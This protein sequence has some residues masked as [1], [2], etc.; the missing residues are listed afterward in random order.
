MTEPGEIISDLKTG[1]EMME[2]PKTPVTSSLCPAPSPLEDD[3][4]MPS[5]AI[6]PKS[7][8]A[9]QPNLVPPGQRSIRTGNP[10][11]SPMFGQNTDLATSSTRNT[12]H[13][14]GRLSPLLPSG[15]GSSA[16]VGSTG[17]TIKADP[18]GFSIGQNADRVRSSAGRFKP[19]KVRVSVHDAD[20]LNPSGQSP[21][22]LGSHQYSVTSP[23]VDEL[24]P[25][26]GVD[27]VLDPDADISINI[28]NSTAKQVVNFPGGPEPS[29]TD[30]EATDRSLDLPVPNAYSRRGAHISTKSEFP[31]IPIPDESSANSRDTSTLNG[32]LNDSLTHSE[33]DSL[34]TFYNCVEGPPSGNNLK[35]KRPQTEHQSFRNSRRSSGKFTNDQLICQT[36]LICQKN[37][38]P[39]AKPQTAIGGPRAARNSR[40]FGSNFGSAISSIGNSRNRSRERDSSLDRSLESDKRFRHG[41]NINDSSFLNS[42]MVNNNFH[43]E[44][45]SHGPI[46]LAEGGHSAA[47]PSPPDN[48]G[49]NTSSLVQQSSKFLPSPTM[50]Q[51]QA[52]QIPNTQG[53]QK[54]HNS[55]AQRPLHNY[56]SGPPTQEQLDVITEKSLGLKKSTWPAFSALPEVQNGF[57]ITSILFRF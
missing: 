50:G 44:V 1:Q 28:T 55:N 48:L 33:K 21:R 52:H 19:G 42:S 14:A 12:I 13:T 29:P 20:L 51:N 25:F 36:D 7:V 39:G 24:N 23:I 45:T 49:P 4:L 17:S 54:V 38:I 34:L 57:E 41:D 27:L 31:L 22:G 47:L 46:F 18:R 10:N 9:Q 11:G 56:L 15:G 40:N 32:G 37:T 26:P 8:T 6:K 3:P 43:A 5:S 2:P 30:T 35:R 16:G 53:S